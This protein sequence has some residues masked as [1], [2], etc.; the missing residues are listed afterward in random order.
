M[1][2]LGS[3]AFNA[4]GATT[5]REVSIPVN[6]QGDKVQV[7]VSV[8]NVGDGVLDSQIVL[9][10][11][12]EKKLAIAKLN[13]RD[14]D[15]NALDFLSTAA[16]TY[17]GGNTRIN[18]TI[19]VQGANSDQ[20]NSLV[21][22]VIQGGKVVATADLAQGVQQMLFQ[23]FGNDEQVEITT[24]QLLFQLPSVQAANIDGTANGTVSLRVKAKSSSGQ[25]VMLGA[26]PR[27]KLVR[28]TGT[29][30]YGQRDENQGGDDWVKPSVKTVIEHFSDVTWGDASNM[31]GGSFPPHSSHRTGI[32]ADGWF[33]GYN[34][35][36][37]AIAATIINYLN[38]PNYGSR[39]RLVFVTYD[40]VNGN[41]FWEA[42][43]NVTLN[44]GRK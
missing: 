21:L 19:T 20:L 4:S 9:D 11:V 30:R 32:D 29:Q 17:F 16:H 38:D 3:A 35:R 41:P 24:S 14:I 42:I 18:G 12:D 27:Q 10:S 44:D 5:F 43:R 34:E 31:N 8:S 40:R 26:A 1:N 33:T 2:G 23:P 13:L 22:E 6:S 25:Q 28:F 7:D 36:N 39:I 15:N 37:A